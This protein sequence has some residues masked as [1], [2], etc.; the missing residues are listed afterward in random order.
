MK[1]RIIVTGGAGF[2]GANL[3][4]GLNQKGFTNITIVDALRSGPK[5]KNLVGLTF[6]DFIHKNDFLS[7]VSQRNY[8][9]DVG[10]IFHLGAC[11]ATTE[12]D[13][14]YLMQNNVHYSISLAEAAIKSNVRFIYASSAATYGLGEQGYLDE[15]KELDTLRPLN[16]YGYSKH[17]FDQ[18]A[19]K[20]KHLSKIVGLK[21]FNVFGPKEFH[22]ENM[23]SMV[24]KAYE[25][26]LG[27][28]QIKLFKSN[29]PK[30]QDGGQMRDFIYVRDCV[31]VM[32]WLLDKPKVNGIFNLGSGKARTWNDLAAAAFKVLNK[33]V[34]IQYIDMHQSLV[35]QYQDY[36]EADM[37]K[38]RRAGYKKE[39]TS[40]E[41][42]VA[43]YLG[44]I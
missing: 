5:W 11:S 20:H 7:K 2:I 12:L 38:L 35:G 29:N 27:T 32:L 4:E 44:R 28:G 39:F 30:F 6:E 19:L 9:K 37:T 15:H 1:K 18:W 8:L 24:I 31:D 25:Q 16:M 34:S 33:P 40:L 42:S 41:D 14:D 10:A 22:K 17:L 26:I 13:A 23:R 43:D 3:V 36:T 21:F